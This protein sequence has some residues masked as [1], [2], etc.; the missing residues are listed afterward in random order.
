MANI[1]ISK[2]IPNKNSKYDVQLKGRFIGQGF[3]HT[4]PAWIDPC[5]DWLQSL[6]TLI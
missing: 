4:H 1:F 3:V 2:Y 5:D 6:L